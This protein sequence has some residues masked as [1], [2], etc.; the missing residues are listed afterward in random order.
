MDC[1]TQFTT[2]VSS[3]SQQLQQLYSTLMSLMGRKFTVYNYH[4][5]TYDSTVNVPRSQGVL[6]NTTNASNFF[7]SKINAITLNKKVSLSVTSAYFVH[8]LV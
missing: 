2:I 6:K 7:I 3:P 8:V 1:L 5:S 4:N